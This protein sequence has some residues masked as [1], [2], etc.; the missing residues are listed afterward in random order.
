VRFEDSVKRKS[1]A[2]TGSRHAGEAAAQ[3][4]DPLPQG[5]LRAFE[6]LAPDL[7]LVERAIVTQFE[8]ASKLLPQVGEDVVRSGD[9]RMRP[10]LL[11][12]ASEL[13]NYTGPRRIEIA[14][15]IELLHAAT[16]VHSEVI[17]R[18]NPREDPL[19]MKT[20]WGNR[21]A[22][23]AGDFFYARTS[24]MIV[25]D[26]DLEILSIVCNTIRGIAE[27]EILQLESRFEPSLAR[28]S[29][30]DSIGRK[31]AMLLSTACEAGAILAEV[32]R[33]ERRALREFGSELGFAMQ[34]RDD[35]LEYEANGSR[36]GEPPLDNLRA[37]KITLP[38]ILTL[39]RC[40]PGERRQIEVALKHFSARA[41]A[42]TNPEFDAKDLEIEALDGIRELVTQH[43]GV[44]DTTEAALAHVRQARA[45]LEAFSLGAARDDLFAFA[46]FALARHR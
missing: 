13:C 19:S 20:V 21:R 40:S 8:S 15:A 30:S 42:Q 44:E 3:P 25:E 16:L 38:L 29:Y 34:L 17:D 45:A 37:G 33:V 24:S 39:E 18:P 9:K 32:T 27:G 4:A 26:G 10:A 2:N 35:A 28:A 6:R 5:V 46:E 22:V 36:P 1:A 41:L 11:L 7:A 12:L 43:R 23:L 14:A 31:S